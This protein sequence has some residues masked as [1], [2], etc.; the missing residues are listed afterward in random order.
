[1][2]IEGGYM[3]FLKVTEEKEVLSGAMK[4]F[5]INGKNILIV[6]YN[7]TYYAINRFCTHLGGD[8]SSGKLEGKTVTCPRH[9]S[10]FDVTTGKCL[11]GP[12]IGFLKLSTADEPSY[13]VKVQGGAVQV[14]L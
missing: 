2:P 5:L 13:E 12:K 14:K 3:E 11:R 10:Q 8:L 9:G 1:M 4:P 6:N 7:N